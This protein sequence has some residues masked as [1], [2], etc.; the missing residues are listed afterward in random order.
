[1]MKYLDGQLKNPPSEEGG[2]DFCAN[3][4]GQDYCGYE[5]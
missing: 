4:M 3:Y 1:M 5:P 2:A